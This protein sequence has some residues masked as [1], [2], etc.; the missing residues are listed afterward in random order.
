MIIQTFRF[1]KKQ[2]LDKFIDKV[3]KLRLTQDEIERLKEQRE[4]EINTSLVKLNN[5]I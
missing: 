3:K 2:I 1:S 5:D 4:Q